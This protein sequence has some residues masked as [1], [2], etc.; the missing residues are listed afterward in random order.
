MTEFEMLALLNN[1]YDSI[2][3]TFINFISVLSGYLIANYFVASKLTTFQYWLMNLVYT[4]LNALFI[5]LEFEILT[6]W[7]LMQEELIRAGPSVDM[8]E[9]GYLAVFSLLLI[10]ILIFAGSLVFSLSCRRASA[11]EA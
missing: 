11:H 7:W 5:Y 9:V 8:P 6:R 2:S 1:Y 10:M 4:T 3:S